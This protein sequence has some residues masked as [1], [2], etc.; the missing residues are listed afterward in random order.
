MSEQTLTCQDERRRGQVRAAGWNGLDYLEVS[1]DQR[2]LTVY[3]IG[4]A[5]EGLVKAN[6]RIEGGRRVRDIQVVRVRLCSQDDPERDDCLVVTVDRPGDFS[7]YRLCLVD[8]D[9][10]GRPTD[11]PYPGLDPR[12]ACLEFSFKV[13]CPSDLDCKAQP[14][15][16]PP[17]VDEPEI[18]YLA[19]DYA[20]L[21]QLILDRLSLVMPGWQERHVPDLGITLVELLAYVGDYLSY[22][23][24][25]V[26]TEAYLDTA[27]QRISVRRHARLVDYRMHE[28][29]N[30]RA[31]VY[32]E[33]SDDLSLD[34][35][36]V[37]F[38]T[39]RGLPLDSTLLQ[40]EDLHN[41]QGHEYEVF[42]PLAETIQLYQA[43]NEIQFYTWGDREC[44]LPRGAT[45]ATLRDEWILP[46]PPQV[47]GSEPYPQPPQQQAPI[48][49]APKTG[50]AQQDRARKLGNLQPGD[51]LIFEEV[52]GPKTNNEADADPTHRHAVRLTR[53]KFGEDALY[54]DPEG[55][56]YPQPVVE[57]EWA[58]ADA[59][60]FALCISVIGPPPECE[61]IEGISVARGNVLLVDHG[62]RIYDEDLGTVP[63]EMTAVVCEGE[64]CPSDVEQVPAR[65]RPVLNRAPLTY[66][67][68]LPAAAPAS[69]LLLQDPR[70][71]LPWIEL[72][73]TRQTSM[74]PVQERWHPRPDLLASDEWD[75]H[76]VVEMDDEGR[77]HLRFGDGELGRVPE[78]GTA[79]ASTYRVGNGPAGNVGAETISHLVL[80]KT[81]LDG[82][83]LRPR[84]P[85]PAIG[86]TRREPLADVK[87]YAPHAFRREL[88][89]AITA[90]DY[91]EIVMR[92]FQEQVQ[93]AAAVLRWTG[94]WYEVLVAIDPR[95]EAEASQAL[96]SEQALLAEIAGHLHRY[97][98]IGHDL[99]VKPAHLVPLDIELQVCV[100]P[101]YLRGHV[102][103]ALLDLF[104]SR[105]LPDGRLGFFHPDNLTFGEG[106]YASKL[107]ALAQA[108]TGV[109]SV[110]VTRL[111]RLFEG[112]NDEI[113]QGV[114]PLGP[115]EVARLDNDPGFPENG[116]FKLVM[117]GGR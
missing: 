64:G 28:G 88:Q 104:S 109:E 112:P 85:F 91:A 11:R 95:N 61:L 71:A 83:T 105:T 66:S 55:S 65:I 51:V 67:Q 36:K 6:V 101:H 27:R 44:C 33:T 49:E 110:T 46:E 13:G 81:K 8:L 98:R 21:R 108:V 84:N 48:Y 80:R 97:R 14:A 99:V 40:W 79:F 1:D 103:A 96:P 4:K 24:D 69:R 20:T 107:V 77:A 39:G 34:P 9:A 58:P 87:L 117:G 35:R 86:G 43:H 31:S 29:N 32:V 30:A 37:S 16:P 62:R 12:Y 26:A 60:P 17:Q 50:P 56:P 45:S 3:F 15:C 115:L 106:I 93:R 19:K 57:I 54:Q 72:T 18:N 75:A 73:G 52:I 5:P 63:V 25:A 53:V 70:R 111:Q 116:L 10:D 68:P 113:E 59:L 41:V 89:R 38:I 92:G 7:T 82:V 76:Y 78:A 22:H 90:G 47:Q 23:Q 114:L 94:S 74:G 42:E 2:T 100:Q 102:Q